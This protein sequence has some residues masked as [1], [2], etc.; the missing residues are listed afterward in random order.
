MIPA[1]NIVSWGRTVPWAE[2]RQV[3][4]D[5][6]I[7]RALVEVFNDDFLRKE[8]R[9]RGG[10]ALNKLHLPKPFRYSE[11]IDLTRTTEGPVGPLLD[12][13]R[14]ILQPWMGQAHYDLGLLGPSLT[15]TMEAEDKT[16]KVPIRVKVEIAT[17][18]RTAYD[19]AR[20]VPFT[21]K[22]PWFTGE[23][24]IETFS[25]EEILA[26][27]L[28][29]LLQRDKG[30]DLIDLSHAH[31]VFG[32]L[33]HA[34]VI[35]IF[36][37][38]LTAAGQAVSRAEAE[39]RMFAK[40]E[41]PSFLADVRPLLAAEEAKKFDAKAERAALKTVFATFIKCIPGEAWKR[42]KERAAEFDM[43]ELAEH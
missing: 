35:T 28:R 43:P 31:A 16:S 6:I 27:K 38:Y 8:L 11:D 18:E 5:L 21:V 17:R 15:F 25:N 14:E 3:E 36:G 12:R 23:A 7:S 13:L 1:M 26:T 22:N 4:Q 9:F 29:A 41:D 10:T 39:E 20:V 40:L 2:L 19:G 37:K 24:D 34:R 42:T 33:D 30:R 32:D